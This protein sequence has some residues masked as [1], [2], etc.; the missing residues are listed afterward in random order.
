MGDH[1]TQ[2]MMNSNESR[3]IVAIYNLN[4]YEGISFNLAKKPRF[5][6]VLDLARNVSKVCQTPNK[7]LI[8][9]YLLDVTNYHNMEC[10]LSLIKKESDN[11]G[12]LFLGIG[13]TISIIPLLKY[14]FQ[15]QTSCSC[16][17][18]C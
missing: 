14:W 8:P 17:R 16:F 11:F 4:I 10:N 18:I 5:K 7:N 6:K 12:F 15:K 13:A 2:K 3:L 1:N 9:K